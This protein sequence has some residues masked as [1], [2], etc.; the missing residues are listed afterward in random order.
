VRAPS[1]QSR[2][3]SFAFVTSNTVGLSSLLSRRGIAAARAPSQSFAQRDRGRREWGDPTER[4]PCASPVMA[5][6]RLP[7]PRRIMALSW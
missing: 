7:E 6:F 2:R 1:A 5:L 3:G 4:S